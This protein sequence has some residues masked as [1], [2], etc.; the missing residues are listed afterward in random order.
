MGVVPL[1]PTLDYPPPRPQ[2]TTVLIKPFFLHISLDTYVPGLIIVQ[3]H[4][5]KDQFADLLINSKRFN[6][7]RIARLRIQYEKSPDIAGCFFYTQIDDPWLL[8]AINTDPAHLSSTVVHESVHLAEHLAPGNEETRARVAQ[9][10]Y[11]L[12][13]DD[14]E[15]RYNS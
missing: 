8:L 2:K 7:E 13:R 9:R 12:F 5:D 10:V 11:K 14:F 3:P 1:V 4:Y 15:R 6:A